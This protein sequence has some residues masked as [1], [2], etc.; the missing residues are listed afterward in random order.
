VNP[1]GNNQN[2]SRFSNLGREAT[3]FA[4][5]SADYVPPPLSAY[6]LAEA[7]GEEEGMVGMLDLAGVRARHRQAMILGWVSGVLAVVLLA[8][9][10]FFWWL[11]LQRLNSQTINAPDLC[12]DKLA[13]VAQSYNQGINPAGAATTAEDFLA[14]TKCAKYETARL[15]AFAAYAQQGKLYDQRVETALALTNYELALKYPPTNPASG[16][17][18]ATPPLP[19]DYP[20]F[21]DWG[22]AVTKRRD[23]IKNYS[24]ALKLSQNYPLLQGD[25]KKKAEAEATALWQRLYNEDPLYAK[26]SPS[27]VAAKL[28][29]AYRDQASLSCQE[30]KDFSS[31]KAALDKAL[32][33]GNN[34]ALKDNI[35]IR[36]ILGGVLETRSKVCNLN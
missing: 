27:G 18:T 36:A 11:G 33:I 16:V 31:G 28:M 3:D 22:K 13:I 7:G 15:F 8:G 26:D 10:T 17:K 9:G 21:E 32:Q 23:F 12:I 6:G 1:D 30:S 2:K 35:N 24:A 34:P 5:L 19:T 25:D 20:S 29:E 14:D 4:E